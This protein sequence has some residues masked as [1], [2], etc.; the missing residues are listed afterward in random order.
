MLFIRTEV[1]LVKYESCIF[2]SGS[3]VIGELRRGCA[4]PGLK[5]RSGEDMFSAGVVL[6]ESSISYVRGSFEKCPASADT[7][8]WRRFRSF[9]LKRSRQPRTIDHLPRNINSQKPLSWT[10]VSKALTER[11]CARTAKQ[12]STA[13]TIPSFLT[14]SCA[15]GRH[16]FLLPPVKAKHVTQ[17][18][19]LAIR[20]SFT[21]ELLSIETKT[22]E[23]KT[24]SAM[25]RR[26]IVAPRHCNSTT[27]FTRR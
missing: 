8:S 9:D 18:M 27:L 3:G 17:G 22:T 21:C 25:I 14:R 20:S 12:T 16:C 4:W 13:M 10:Q 19:A 7:N 15:C 11:I 23:K 6:A 2:E 5:T 26:T 24:T 1:F